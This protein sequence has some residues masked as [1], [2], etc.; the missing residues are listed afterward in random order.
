VAQELARSVECPARTIP[1][2]K[3]YTRDK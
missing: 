2:Q 1:N 3:G